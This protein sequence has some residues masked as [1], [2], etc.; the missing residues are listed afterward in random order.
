MARG[1]P[2]E[3]V[4]LR[5]LAVASQMFGLQMAHVS[6]GGLTKNTVYVILGRLE[7]QGHVVSELEERNGE[8]YAPRRRLYQI[9]DAGRVR[10]R[11]YE[12]MRE[13][14]ATI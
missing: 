8:E 4:A 6:C 11:E 9:T 13:Y 3:I 7:H 2:K 14:E 5:L 12:A 1:V 10:L